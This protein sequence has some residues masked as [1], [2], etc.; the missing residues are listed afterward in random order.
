MLPPVDVL[1]LLLAWG[2]LVAVDLVSLPQAMYSRPVVAGAVAGWLTGDLE[3]GFRIGVL[4]E[5]FALDV[6]PVGA[7][8]YPDY[9]PATVAGVLAA[10]GAA[11][12]ERTGLSVL[13]ALSLAVLGGWSMQRL[14]MANASAM[15]ARAA[16]LA[17]GSPGAI[18]AL[19]WGGLGRDVVRGMTL[20]VI[21]IALAL[22]VRVLPPMSPR[23]EAT[24]AAVAVGGG[25]MAVAGGA[26]RNAGRGRRLAWLAV[27]LAAGVAIA[28]ARAVR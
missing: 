17:A 21:G 4:L 27:G 15:Q 26:W 24:A 19:H 22:L 7:A 1:L 20:M 13:L 3:A 14:R 10:S 18:T 16:A 9:G 12:P 25:I 5:L 2:T 8:R 23:W 11:W 28:V 6:L